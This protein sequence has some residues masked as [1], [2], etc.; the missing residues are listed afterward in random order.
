MK[1]LGFTMVGAVVVGELAWGVW[2]VGVWPVLAVVGVYA[3]LFLWLGTAAW[4]ITR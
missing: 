2:L 1:A 3:G 4:L